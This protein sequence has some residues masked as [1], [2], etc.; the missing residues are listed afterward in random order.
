MRSKLD[1]DAYT[2]TKVQHYLVED[3]YSETVIPSIV[4]RMVRVIRGKLEVV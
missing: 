4:E 3:I 2:G 1:V